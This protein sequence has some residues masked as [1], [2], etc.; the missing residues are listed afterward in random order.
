MP[1]MHL[2]DCSVHANTS[3]AMLA[4]LSSIIN[5]MISDFKEMEFFLSGQKSLNQH[6]FGDIQASHFIH[7]YIRSDFHF[8]SNRNLVGDKSHEA[9]D[10]IFR[11]LIYDILLC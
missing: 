2:A 3:P 5:Y 7:L 10:N 6:S 1:G 11:H 8:E 9:I 4:A